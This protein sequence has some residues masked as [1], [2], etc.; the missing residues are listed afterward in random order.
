M[1]LVFSLALLADLLLIW[2]DHLVAFPGLYKGLVFK[3]AN[4]VNKE[5]AIVIISLFFVFLESA[6][7]GWI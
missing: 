3:F 5:K 6:Y 1:L 4:V 2:S 7:I